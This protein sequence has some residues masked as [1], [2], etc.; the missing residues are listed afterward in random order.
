MTLLF[1]L[2]HGA[3]AE[4]GSVGILATS[5][6]KFSA[7]VVA[8]GLRGKRD[9]TT[10]LIKSGRA[11]LEWSVGSSE[12]KKRL[13]AA[14]LGRAVVPRL[15]SPEHLVLL[16]ATIGEHTVRGAPPG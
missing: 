5:E 15:S 14:A 4:K 2:I 3:P 7:S 1:W 16:W 11:R 13:K 12:W 9:G 8:A 10:Q 6:A